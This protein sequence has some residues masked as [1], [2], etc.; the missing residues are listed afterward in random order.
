MSLQPRTWPRVPEQTTAVARAAFPKGTLAIRVRDE[1]PELFAEPSWTGRW[2][3][4]GC[5][6]VEALDAS[7]VGF[8]CCLHGR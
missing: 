4:L 2:P 1:L 7:Y 3:S 6:A 8:P 5:T